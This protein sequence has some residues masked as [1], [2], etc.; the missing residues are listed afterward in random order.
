MTNKLIP[1]IDYSGID[2]GYYEH[3]LNNFKSKL[4][5]I[6]DFDPV[7]Y[8]NLYKILYFLLIHNDHEFFD[9]S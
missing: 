5:L 8:S 1:K 6:K 7:F 2:P 3:N 9:Y 4:N